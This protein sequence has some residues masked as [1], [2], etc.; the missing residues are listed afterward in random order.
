MSGAADLL[1]AIVYVVFAHVAGLFPV[2]AM[3]TVMVEPVIVN[4][5]GDPEVAALPLTVI[6]TSAG[7]VAVGVTVKLVVQ[8]GTSAIE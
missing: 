5:E 1:I 2:T 7:A 6:S 8:Y 3:V 4:E